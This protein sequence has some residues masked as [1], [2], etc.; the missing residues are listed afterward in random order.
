[1]QVADSFIEEAGLNE[2]DEGTCDEEIEVPYFC[3]FFVLF[4]FCPLFFVLF[5][6]FNFISPFLQHVYFWSI[7]I[8]LC[9]CFHLI[10]VNYISSS[11]KFC[12]D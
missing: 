5:G 12:S 8:N 11:S 3:P 4:G 6:P 10:E 2:G 7:S 1:M 9:M